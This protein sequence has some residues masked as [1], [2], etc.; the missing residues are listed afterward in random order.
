MHLKIYNFLLSL[1]NGTKKVELKLQLAKF[2]GNYAA[3]NYIGKLREPILEAY[4][5]KL[6]QE[7]IESNETSIPHKKE[8]VLHVFTQTFTTG[9]HT[10]LAQNIVENDSEREHHLVATHQSTI[11]ENINLIQAIQQSGGHYSRIDDP[12]IISAAKQLRRLSLNSDK[13]FLYINSDDP[14]P[15]IALQNLPE[16]IEVIL[17][18]HSDHAFSFGFD[19]AH[20]VINIR[21]EAHRITVHLRKHTNSFVLP[22]IISK[23]KS[24]MGNDEV[25]KSL[26]LPETGIMAITIGTTHKYKANLKYDFFRTIHQA[27]LENPNLY[28]YIIGFNEE[29]Y[30]KEFKYP[31]N[32]RLK[33]LG[34]IEDPKDYLNAAEIIVDPMP[35]GSYTALLEAALFGAYP[36]L[37]YDTIPLF[38]VYNYPEFKGLF[39]SDRNESE[40]L[41]HLRT[42]C[43]DSK[44]RNDERIIF[45]IERHHSLE[46]WLI[47]Y[48]NIL[49]K[50]QID[51]LT[52]I[53]KPVQ[54][55]EFNQSVTDV[56]K[57][58]LVFFYANAQLFS[59][60]NI[61]R[62]FCFLIM[63]QFDLRESLGI[64]K[65]NMIN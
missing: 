45:A 2:I 60:I 52:P 21:D 23:R 1:F 32:N 36:L 58:L 51:T 37:C 26:E 13:V 50:E 4:F 30:L 3:W 65:K 62:I 43:N 10:R 5:Q 17:I 18:N 7:L 42:L 28:L 53:P 29:D 38:N 46:N 35:Y 61:L 39:T 47:T 16:K 12:H 64:L 9:G 34:L 40:Y 49:S 41:A 44:I 15:S 56:R 48:N 54:F 14:I 25:R 31:L 6:G 11:E 19:V 33:F 63:N 55:E 57:R 59:K 27:L 24:K 8:R 22:L 20:K